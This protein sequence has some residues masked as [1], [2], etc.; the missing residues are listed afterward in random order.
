[1][2]FC[3]TENPYLTIR[4]IYNTNK[5]LW[6]GWEPLFQGVNVK[7]KPMSIITESENGLRRSAYLNMEQGDAIKTEF[8]FLKF[9]WNWNSVKIWFWQTKTILNWLKAFTPH[10]HWEMHKCYIIKVKQFE[11]KL[12]TWINQPL[13]LKRVINLKRLV[14]AFITIS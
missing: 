9:C 10:I 12:Y 4:G 13:K 8:T 7:Q 5:W 14:M 11:A 6:K 1:M 2:C 3:E